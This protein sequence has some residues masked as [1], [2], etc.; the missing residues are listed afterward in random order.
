MA[1]QFVRFVSPVKGRLVSRWDAP[2]TYVG[3]R[4]ATTAE[5]AAGSD[6]VI[7]DEELVLP[8][9]EAFCRRFDKEL[10]SALRNGDLRERKA[11]DYRRW[12]ETERKRDAAA[13]P[14]SKQAAAPEE[15][16]E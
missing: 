4:L 9:T 3:A 1:V 14:K 10:R 7:W 16:G 2:G 15:S 11:D 13:H 8:L 6:G 5:R 12:L